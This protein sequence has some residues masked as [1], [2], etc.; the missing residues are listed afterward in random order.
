MVNLCVAHQ[1]DHIDSGH[2]TQN[3]FNPVFQ[4][5]SFNPSVVPVGLKNPVNDIV[6]L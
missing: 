5:S 4:A 6:C 2:G 1:A 3:P